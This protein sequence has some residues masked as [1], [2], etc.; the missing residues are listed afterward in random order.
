MDNPVDGPEMNWLGTCEYERSLEIQG[1]AVQEV[2]LSSKAQFLSC[3]HPTVITLG[4]RGQPLTDILASLE[5]LREK[6]IKIVA[7]ERGGQATLHNPGQLVIYPI[8][9]LKVWGIGVREYV[10]CLERAT[11]HYLAE[12]GMELERGAEPGLYVSGQKI[13]AFGIRVD[14]GVTLHGL[15]ININNDLQSFDFIRQCGQVVRPTNLSLEMSRF[16]AIKEDW[17]FEE[18]SRKWMKLFLGGI[19]RYR[20]PFRKLGANPDGLA[21]IV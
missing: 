12:Y 7:T 5:V 15:A 9:P 10:E 21:P 17:D 14:R 1:R 20:V 4:K 8:I 6:N 13:A 11:A 16:G 19:R 18:E 3:E 2:K